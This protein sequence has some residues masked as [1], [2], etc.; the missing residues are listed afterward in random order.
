M[1]KLLINCDN[2]SEIRCEFANS[3]Y[4]RYQAEVYLLRPC[5]PDYDQDNVEELKLKINVINFDKPCS[6][7]DE[8]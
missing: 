8:A 3:V 7:I 1:S 6:V 5:T 2:N 4:E